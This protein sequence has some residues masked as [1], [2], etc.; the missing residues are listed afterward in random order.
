VLLDVAGKPPAGLLDIGQDR[1]H[2]L[3]RP[4]D[5]YRVGHARH[6]GAPDID[7]SDTLIGMDNHRAFGI[8]TRV[9]R[10]LAALAIVSIAL[11]FGSVSAASRPITN[12]AGPVASL[13]APLPACAYRDILTARAAYAQYSTTLLDTIY[14]LPSA[15][16][17]RDLVGTGLRGGG[18]VRRIALADLRAMNRAAR[19]AGARFA[20]ASAFRSY[21]RQ[22]LMFNTRVA[23]VGRAVALR[24]VARPGH[25]EHQLGTAIDFRSYDGRTPFATTRAGAWMKAN[26]WKFGW[27][28]SYPSGKAAVTCYAY[29]PWHYRYVGRTVARLIH[30]SGLTVRQWIWR[31]FGS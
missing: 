15:Y 24:T 5:G 25:S 10:L 19:L 28:M 21:S 9:G 17:P 31:H 20:V 26:A 22:A 7:A 11:P 18:F 6:L 16:Y 23:L 29:E 3:D 14:R 12:T 4:P 2:V 30:F 27:L 8:K 13:V 1:E